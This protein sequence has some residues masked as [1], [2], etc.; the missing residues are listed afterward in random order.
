FD[1]TTQYVSTTGTHAFVAP[2]S[3]DARGPC[4]GLNALVNHGYIPH[5]GMGLLLNSLRLPIKVRFIAWALTWLPLLSVYGT[6][7]DGD[8]VSLSFSIGQGQSTILG[9]ENGLTES[10]NNYEADVSPTR[11]AHRGNDDHDVQLSQFVQLY[12]LQSIVSDPSQVNYD[13]PLLTSFRVTRFQQTIDD[14]QYFFNAALGGLAVQPAASQFIFRPMGNKSEEYP[15]GRLNRDTLKS[16]FA[17]SGPDDLDHTPG[18]ERIPDNDGKWI[19]YKRAIGD[20]YRLEPLILDIITM[21]FAHP[22]FLSIGGNTG[23][24]NTFTGVDVAD[25]TGGVYN[26]ATLLEGNNFQCFS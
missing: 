8:I 3:G 11:E 20:E 10:H 14:N 6:A 23:Q 21:A 12:D 24:V 15:E 9:T 5:N 18:H 13:I 25:L 7:V 1:P 26:A 19:L 16:F 22:Q 2:G 17:I 4:P